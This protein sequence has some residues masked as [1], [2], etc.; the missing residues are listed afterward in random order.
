[1]EFAQF[2][3]LRVKHAPQHNIAREES[4]VPQRSFAAHRGFPALHKHPAQTEQHA[5]QLALKQA[6]APPLLVGMILNA[7]EPSRDRLSPLRYALED[8]ASP[9]AEQ[10]AEPLS[11]LMAILVQRQEHAPQPA[12]LADQNNVVTMED[13]LY[14][15]TPH[16]SQETPALADCPVLQRE[17]AP[18]L[19]PA[20]L[21]ADQDFSAA[22]TVFAPS[23]MEADALLERSARTEPLA[24]QLE[25]AHKDAQQSP[26]P[27]EKLANKDLAE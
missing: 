24:P 17:P 20:T 16:A 21:T 18:H 12:L 22:I 15:Q 3:L 23:L 19:A 6:Y 9:W 11:A 26:A 2:P 5:P 1:M 10:D 4:P 14:L 27:L 8:S 13:A 25:H 7:E